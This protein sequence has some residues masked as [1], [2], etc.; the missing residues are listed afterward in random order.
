[1]VWDF[2]LRILFVNTE[3]T[4]LEIPRSFCKNDEVAAQLCASVSTQL[5]T[6]FGDCRVDAINTCREGSDKMVS[7]LPPAGE[8]VVISVFLTAE[9]QT[10]SLHAYTNAVNDIER[11]V[12]LDFIH[13]LV[14]QKLRN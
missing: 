14:S 7:S 12:L 3:L 10:G 9:Q 5:Y 1:M 13:R 11:I 4:P 8:V 6:L 2:L